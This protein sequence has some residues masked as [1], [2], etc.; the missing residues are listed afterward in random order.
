MNSVPVTVVLAA[1]AATIHFFAG[2]SDSCR[3]APKTG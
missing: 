1:T 2:S 3:M